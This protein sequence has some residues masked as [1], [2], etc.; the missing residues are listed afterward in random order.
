M[1]D[2]PTEDKEAEDEAS[3]ENIVQGC[4]DS[5]GNMSPD[6][7]NLPQPSVVETMEDEAPVLEKQNLSD[8][9]YEIFYHSIFFKL[10]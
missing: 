4:I 6:V 10:Y 1:E 5:I 7:I 9:M 2:F 3:F 8:G